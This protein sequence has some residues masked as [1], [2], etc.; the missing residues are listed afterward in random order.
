MKKKR[1]LWNLRRI[2]L[3]TVGL[4]LI[5]LLVVVVLPNVYLALTYFNIPA[6]LPSYQ[7]IQQVVIDGR[8]DELCIQTQIPSS[9]LAFLRIKVVVEDSVVPFQELDIQR[10]QLPNLLG[11]YEVDIVCTPLE[12]TS[13]VHVVQIISRPSVF[14]EYSTDVKI[15]VT[16]DGLIQQFK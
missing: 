15:H 9:T 16:E 1:K 11:G 7:G 8:Q 14:H 2:F 6:N 12:L 3:G 13:G 5:L 4:I 10:T